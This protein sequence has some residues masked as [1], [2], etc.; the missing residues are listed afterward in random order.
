MRRYKALLFILIAAAAILAGGVGGMLLA[1]Y[2][3]LP[4]VTALEEYKPSATTRVF[5]DDGELLAEFY[6]ENRT[7]VTLARVPAHVIKA[8]LATE[9]PRFYSHSGIDF[10]GI[11]RAMFNNIRAGKIVQGGSSITQQ[12]A[13]LLFLEPDKTFSRKVKEALLAIQIERRYSKD[14]ILTLYLNQ[15]Y[16]G[17]GAYGVEAAARTYFGKPVE[18]L[19]LA[20]GAMLAGLP[21]APNKYSPNNDLDKAYARRRHVLKRMAE[22]GFI[23][24][25]AM[26]AADREPYVK[27]P[28]K[29]PVYKAPYFVEYIRQK[30]ED[31]YGST[32]LYRGGLNV[33]TTLDAKM[34]DIAEAAM[35]KGLADLAKRHP[36][37]DKEI[38]GA[39]LA[40]EPRSGNIKAMIGGRDFAKS[41]FN[42]STQALRQP[43]SA[44][45]P[46][47]FAAALD[48][49][50]SPDD[51]VL[52]VPVSYPGARPGARWRPTNFD[53][54]F[55]GPVTLRHALARSINVVA[56]RLLDDIGVQTAIDYARRLG[57]TAPMPPY[58][59]L[60]LGASDVTLME[61]TTAF[62]VF[63]NLGLYTPPTGIEKVTDR[64]GRV[65]EENTAQSRQAMSADTA[66]AMTDMLTGVI[67]FGTG[68]EAKSLGRPAAGKTGTTSAYNDAWFIGYLP[69]IVAGVWVGYDDHK[70]IGNRETGARA[71]LPIWLEFMKNY[72]KASSLPAEEFPTPS[73]PEFRNIS[74]LGLK[75]NTAGAEETGVGQEEA[76]AEGEDTEGSPDNQ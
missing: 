33:Y 18:K 46:I 42:R 54:K 60:A 5:A 67:K 13:K 43:G 62:A 23:S 11:I 37:K 10:T 73:Q 2:S 26:T 71:A 75:V 6:M 66:A 27:L 9:D 28:M 14:E 20:E 49:G 51:V 25:S 31:K 76:P 44:F 21:A 70:T 29:K 45:K 74:G 58:L 41:E 47:V 40:I 7:P 35:E 63:D 59:P 30:L 22:E 16:L 52:D 24:G 48:K 68:W 15:V 3:D 19:T 12:L 32:T 53:N 17:S 39:F 61:M 1:H 38:Q 50:Y 55:E 64:E 56:V 72:V 57:I 8:F 36:R 65:I 34:Q 4:Q 69:S